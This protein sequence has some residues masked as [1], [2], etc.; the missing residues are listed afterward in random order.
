MSWVT[1]STLLFL[2]FSS[3]TL[4]CSPGRSPE[5]EAPSLFQPTVRTGQAIAN[6]PGEPK[7]PLLCPMKN[8]EK[9]ISEL[10][11]LGKVRS[12]SLNKEWLTANIMLA[13]YSRAT[14][15]L[16]SIIFP[17]TDG[18]PVRANIN[19]II[20]KCDGS[21]SMMEGRSTLAAVEA[22]R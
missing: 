15:P 7:P 17:S 19:T 18:V 20:H 4:A 8:K 14:F 6:N 5:V 2:S 16:F 1:S 13:A 10:I 12:I 21:C 9:V 22:P 11:T 3:F